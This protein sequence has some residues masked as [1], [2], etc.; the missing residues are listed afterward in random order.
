MIPPSVIM[1]IYGILTETSVGQLFVAGIIPGLITVVAYSITIILWAK[2][3]PQA[4]PRTG[5][6]RDRG[7]G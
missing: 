7:R 5:V 3:V 6:G 1:V 2:Y 4:A